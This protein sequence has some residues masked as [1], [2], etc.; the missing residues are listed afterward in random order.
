MAWI[1]STELNLNLVSRNSIG[2]RKKQIQSAAHRLLFF[3]L[4]RN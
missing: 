3:T 1:S 2:I 4:Y